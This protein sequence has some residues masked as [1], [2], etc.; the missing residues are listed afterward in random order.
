MRT[1][2]GSWGYALG[3]RS[4]AYS[5]RGR[6]GPAE[7]S[8]AIQGPRPRRTRSPEPGG[9]G[10]F[11]DFFPP[12][13]T[14]QNRVSVDCKST[15]HQR[16]R[17]EAEGSDDQKSSM[18]S[19]R[20]QNRT[21]VRHHVDQTVHL[22]IL[23]R[24]DDIADSQVKIR[25]SNPRPGCEADSTAPDAIRGPAKAVACGEGMERTSHR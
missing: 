5:R 16:V 18:I 12:G 15:K 9:R 17:S 11:L 23:G 3:S 13:D 6:P 22:S 4:R 2:S 1:R 7:I 24:M 20:R 21:R 10:R 19:G 14:Q 8:P 25:V